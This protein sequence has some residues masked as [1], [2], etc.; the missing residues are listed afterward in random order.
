MAML[1]AVTHSAATT[2][3][4]MQASLEMASAVKVV[5]T[6]LCKL[7]Y[8]SEHS[9][10]HLYCVDINEC[11]V[12]NGG[13]EQLCSNTVGS[14]LCDCGAGYQLDNNGFNCSGK[15]VADLQ[16]QNICIFIHL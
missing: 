1:H 13:C 10:M 5:D 15:H 8:L 6:I 7:G 11:N 14:F 3:Y 12:S 4:A 9:I 2:A 16:S